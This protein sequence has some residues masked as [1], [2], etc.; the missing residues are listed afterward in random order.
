MLLAPVALLTIPCLL[1]CASHY[2]RD[3]DKVKHMV[4]EADK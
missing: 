1:Q 3:M 4:L 2:P